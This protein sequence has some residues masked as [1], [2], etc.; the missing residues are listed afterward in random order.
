M[1]ELEFNRYNSRA[2]NRKMT[3]DDRLE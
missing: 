2:K 1:F 3:R